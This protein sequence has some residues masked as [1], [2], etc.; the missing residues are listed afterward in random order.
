M[1]KVFI[2]MYLRPESGVETLKQ[3]ASTNQ[4]KQAM[5]VLHHKPG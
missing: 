5:N 1:Y 4:V 2:E 3:T